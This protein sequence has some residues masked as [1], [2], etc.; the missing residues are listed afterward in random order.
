MKKLFILLLP[1]FCGSCSINRFV[2][3]NRQIDLFPVFID[4]DSVKILPPAFSIHDVSDRNE[5]NYS[6]NLPNK[7]EIFRKKIQDLLLSNSVNF[8]FYSTSPECLRNKMHIQN[9]RDDKWFNPE[10][11]DCISKNDSFYTV[12][13]FNQLEIV[14]RISYGAVPMADHSDITTLLLVFKKKKIVYVRNFRFAKRLTNKEQ[15]GFEEHI[16]VYPYFKTEQIH[17]VLEKVTEDL[18]KRIKPA[19]VK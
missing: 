19:N 2:L 9:W 10:T 7:E 12:L 18:F 11:Y 17:H 16:N 1:F 13:F 5:L 8:A 15:M 3:K 6:L 14:E 4:S